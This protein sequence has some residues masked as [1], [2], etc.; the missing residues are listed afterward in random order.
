MGGWHS[1]L[2]KGEGFFLSDLCLNESFVRLLELFFILA[3]LEL[4]YRTSVVAFGL[5][6]V[7]GDP[8]LASFFLEVGDLEG[9]LKDLVV[10]GLE[11][12]RDARRIIVRVAT[13]LE[14]FLRVVANVFYKLV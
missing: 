1:R 14:L 6:L 12:T 2:G 9:L 7:T 13:E 11:F 4:D 3:L 10:R 5:G 8:D